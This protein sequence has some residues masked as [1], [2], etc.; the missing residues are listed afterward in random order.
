[1][2]AKV[3]LETLR[4]VWS[5]V[6]QQN[7]DAALIGGIAMAAWKYPRATRDV[8]IMVS[9]PDE[10]IDGLIASLLR[11]GVRSKDDTPIDLGHIDVIRLEYEPP[12]AFVDVPI[13]LLVARSDYARAAIKRSVTLTS[14]TLG[15]EVRVMACEDL[16]INKLLAGRVIDLA[17]S[18][19]LIRANVGE[20]DR[21]YL[22]D[23]VESIGLIDQ[24]KRIWSEAVPS[25]PLR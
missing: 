4:H 21:D 1:M 25:K 16:I 24:L 12:G 9:L 15:F 14:E 7:I 18:A 19:A 22:I 17:D 8:D 20:I 13:D 3:V 11:T 6:A 23:Q 5:T 2:A 10:Q